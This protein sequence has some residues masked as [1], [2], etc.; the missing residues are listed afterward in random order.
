LVAKGGTTM[1]KTSIGYYIIASAVI[2]GLVIIGCS[3][4]LKGTACYDEISTIL[5]GGAGAHLLFIWGPLAG[6][7]VLRKKP[8][9][10]AEIEQ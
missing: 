5:V 10:E 6:R 1:E 2:W 3:L 4:R 7:I 9:E 8:A